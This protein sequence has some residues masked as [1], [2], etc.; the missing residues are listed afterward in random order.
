MPVLLLGAL[1]ACGGGGG[2]GASLAS[3]QTSGKPWLGDTLTIYDPAKNTYTGWSSHNVQRLSYAHGRIGLGSTIRAR[4]T[5]ANVQVAVVDEGIDVDHP[6]L[7]GNILKKQN[8]D[9]VGKNYILPNSSNFEPTT[10]R[11]YQAFHMVRMSRVLSPL[12]IMNVV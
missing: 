1:A 5:G 9:I 6:D 11:G 7:Q 12:P 4:N 3:L 10:D 8:G 2:G